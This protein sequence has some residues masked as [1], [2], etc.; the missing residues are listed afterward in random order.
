MVGGRADRQETLVTHY[1]GGESHYLIR[2]A[3]FP[4]AP[5]MP[6]IQLN[7]LSDEE[8]PLVT[9]TSSCEVKKNPT[10]KR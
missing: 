2:M 10:G 7:P 4:G 6:I 1:D 8:G 3:F 5:D 9:F